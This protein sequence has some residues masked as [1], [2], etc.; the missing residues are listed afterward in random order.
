MEEVLRGSG[1]ECAGK[2]FA[3]RGKSEGK[4]W[5]AGLTGVR[6]PGLGGHVREGW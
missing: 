4:G 2:G 3:G 1:G 5:E 6:N